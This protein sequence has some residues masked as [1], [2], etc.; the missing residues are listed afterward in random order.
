[1]TEV[2]DG[3]SNRQGVDIGIIGK[4]ARLY[5][6]TVFERIYTVKGATTAEFRR[7]WGL[8]EEYARKERVNHTH[9]CLDAIVIACI[10]RN[11]YD[12]WA[13][14]AGDEERYRRGEGAKPRFEKPW[15]TFT[16]DLEAVADRL[17]IAHHTPDNMPKQSRKRLRI[18]GRI[19]TGKNGETLYAQGDTARGALHQQTFYGAIE[20]KGEVKYVVRK[21]L[22]QLQPSDVD[23]IV[24]DAVRQKVKEAIDAVGFKTAMDTES[25]PIWMNEQKRVPIRKVRIFAGKNISPKP[26]GGKKHRDLSALPHKRPVYVSYGSNYCMAI[27]EG[28]DNQGK[29]KRT[30]EIVSTLEAA[31]YFKASADKAARP[32]LVPQSDANG[33]PLKC[34][35]KT[36]TM[37]LFYEETPEELYECTQQELA[38]R[39]YKL[40]KFSSMTTGNNSYG[41]CTF[42]H[43][44]EARPA[45]ELKPKGGAWKAGEAYRPLISLYHT[46]LNAYVEG[47][48]FELSVT[49]TVRFKHE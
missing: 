22:G 47:F 40:T 32:D 48:D 15:P 27:Y 24:D 16:E 1:M 46:Q 37:V 49:G 10:G 18:R 21:P 8:Q 33:F 23:N 41:L 39:L 12:R 2:P 9:H 20:R 25:H 17:L 30:F 29:L 3:F 31:Q 7:M 38:K 14:Y 28:K 5:L 44:Q 13:Q 35:L 34:I 42:R 6:K 19:R 11:E 4:Y 43:H 45:G 36:G 26:L